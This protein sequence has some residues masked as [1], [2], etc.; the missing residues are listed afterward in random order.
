[1][2]KKTILLVEDQPK[3]A[4][5]IKEILGHEYLLETARSSKTALAVLEKKKP[6]LIIIDYDLKGEDG[7]QVFKSLGATVAVIMLS[8]SGNIPLAVSA[9]KLG[10]EEFLRKPI[11]APALK[12]A[13]EK[14]IRRTELTLFGTEEIAWLSGGSPALKDLFGGI[15][16]ALHANKDIIITGAL[17]IPLAEVAVLLHKNSP[18]NK[19]R[20]GHF[21]L[22]AFNNEEQ[23]TYFWAS[24][25]EQLALPEVGSVQSS[26]DR[27]GMIYLENLEAADPLFRKSLFKFLEERSGK[28]D[29]SIR[30]VFGIRDRS[31]IAT[32][33]LKNFSL[34]EVPGLPARKADL[35]YLLETYLQKYS[36]KYNKNI[37]LVSTDVLDF[38]TTY[39]YPGNYL[40]FEH[41]IEAAVLA[42][43]T[44]K[45]E[46]D[47]FP[48][49]PKAWLAT[50]LKKC[51]RENLT[52]V[53]AKNRFEKN[54][55]YLLLKKPTQATAPAQ[56][57]P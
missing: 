38:L 5:L 42:T 10:V 24:L 17:G 23:E 45:L 26:E 11:S 19:N 12:Q 4:H 16:E 57:P 2:A 27:C 55:Y 41:L 33:K 18:K 56:W 8:A 15:Q 48:V 36:R 44:D 52:L 21:D 40:E 29:K 25:Q 53:E 35:S 28:I 13:I 37:K 9:T 50:N 6:D 31:I 7:L 1:M 22:A 3:T 47:A 20:L 14:N 32:A 49:A 34:I 51:A 39:D 46:L 43:K 30:A 54:L